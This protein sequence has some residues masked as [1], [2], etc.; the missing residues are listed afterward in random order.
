[1]VSMSIL[2]VALCSKHA[3]MLSR[4]HTMLA[5]KMYMF[6]QR[7]D[8]SKA[9]KSHSHTCGSIL[10][11]SRAS[12]LPHSGSTDPN[13]IHL[14]RTLNKHIRKT[15]FPRGQNSGKVWIRLKIQGQFSHDNGVKALNEPV[16][17]SQIPRSII[18]AE[19][20][21]PVAAQKRKKATT[22]ICV[23]DEHEMIP[24]SACQFCL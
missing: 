15:R 23:C 24:W 5:Y 18:S 17:M 10:R 11:A 4:Q 2:P 16:R 9:S 20:E 14:D 13:G 12:H 19:S 1:M 8:F 7:P 3:R 22:C 21:A 6:R